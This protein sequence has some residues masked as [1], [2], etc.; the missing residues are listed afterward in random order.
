MMNDDDVDDNYKNRELLKLHTAGEI[1][2]E[3]FI[4]IIII[5]TIYRNK[6]GTEIYTPNL[7]KYLCYS[8]AYVFTLYLFNFSNTAY[9]YKYRSDNN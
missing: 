2:K 7:F 3:Y 6:R 5:T 1:R 4:I 8:S 9:T